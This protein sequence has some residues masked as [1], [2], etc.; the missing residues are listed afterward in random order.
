MQMEA[1][2]LLSRLLQTYTISL[3]EDYKMVAL[4]KVSLEPKDDVP[5]TLLPRQIS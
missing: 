4:Q 2:I 1:K 3:P 5:C